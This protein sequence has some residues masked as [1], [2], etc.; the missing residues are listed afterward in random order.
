[1]YKFILLYSVM[2]LPLSSIAEMPKIPGTEKIYRI[3][4]PHSFMA[5]YAGTATWIPSKLG[6]SYTYSPDLM[7]SY[8]VSFLRGNLAA[9]FFLKDLG[10]ISDF[11]LSALYRSYSARNSFAVI[12]GLNYY[13]FNARMSGK[14]TNSASNTSNPDLNLLL[15]ESIGV[16]FGL[17]NRWQLKN[18]V[19]FGVDWFH[20]NM[21]LIVFRTEADLLKS[22]ADK[23][24]KNEI[25]NVLD[26]LKR[27]PTFAFLKFQI[28]YSF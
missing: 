23:E 15:V 21:P 26:L 13:K 20:L 1:M 9:P 3:Q 14:Y 16:T 8:E 18:G 6:L 25:K 17:G 19:S 10:S 28:G 7:K 2:L 24:D 22:D 5:S 27:V 12:Y 11:H 4:N